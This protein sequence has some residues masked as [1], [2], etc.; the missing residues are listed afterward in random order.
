MHHTDRELASG[1]TRIRWENVENIE[2]RGRALGHV[3]LETNQ[4]WP[5]E[6]PVL[7]GTETAMSHMNHTSPSG[8]TLVEGGALVLAIAVVVV[9]S[10]GSAPYLWSAA[11]IIVGAWAG[12]FLRCHALR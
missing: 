10:F 9:G 2:G 7:A 3:A 4:P 1:F 12:R 5:A 11:G 6:G 8:V